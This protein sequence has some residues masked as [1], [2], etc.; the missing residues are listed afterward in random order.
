MFDFLF[1]EGFNAVKLHN[2]Q[3]AS[4]QIARKLRALKAKIQS[5]PTT[6]LANLAR[7]F[8]MVFLAISALH[9]ESIAR[10]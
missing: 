1:F 9:L 7:S 2:V 3:I 5:F 10:A 6:T 4:Q 8:F